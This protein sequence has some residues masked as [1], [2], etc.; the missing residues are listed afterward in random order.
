MINKERIIQE[1][2]AQR[3]RLDTVIEVF[4]ALPEDLPGEWSYQASTTTNIYAN[5]GNMDDRNVVRKHLGSTVTPKRREMPLTVQQGSYAEQLWVY[6]SV[7]RVDDIIW[8]RGP[9]WTLYLT[10][11]PLVEGATCRIEQVDVEEVPIWKVVRDE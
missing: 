10:I 9:R 7:E 2:A 8:G 6:E 11:N 3:E 5:T 4:N 1:I